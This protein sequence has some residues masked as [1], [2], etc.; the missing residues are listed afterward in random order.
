MENIYKIMHILS[1]HLK[2]ICC[3]QD[4]ILRIN[5]RKIFTY[6]TKVLYNSPH[7][8]NHIGMTNKAI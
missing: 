3:S 1:L 7:M 6:K 2:D 5:G 8:H 4:R